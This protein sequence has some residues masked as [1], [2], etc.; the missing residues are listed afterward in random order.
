M[1][2]DGL[3]EFMQRMDAYMNFGRGY[4]CHRRNLCVSI[5]RDD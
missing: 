5:K 1:D 4:L 2:L 3:R